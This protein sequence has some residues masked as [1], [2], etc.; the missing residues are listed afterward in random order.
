MAGLIS[1][2][3]PKNYNST[4]ST[5]G[6]S[7]SPSKLSAALGD[8]ADALRE[9]LPAICTCNHPTLDPTPRVYEDKKYSPVKRVAAASAGIAV[10]R[11]RAGTRSRGN[12][13][14]LSEPFWVLEHQSW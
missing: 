10:A 1:Q 7:G 4:P 12:A 14:L 5:V 3:D 8:A 6:R 2:M 13:A 11:K 9:A